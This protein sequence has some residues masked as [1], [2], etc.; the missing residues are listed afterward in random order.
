MKRFLSILIV[1]AF[2]SQLF[3]LENT[4]VVSDE[5]NDSKIQVYYF[6]LSRRC[7]TCQAVESESKKA[8]EAL[9]PEKI[10]NGE[11]TFLSVNIEEDENK[12]LAESLEV[13]GQTLLFVMGDKKVNLTNDGF[14]Y[15]K[16][17]PDKLQIKFKETIDS[18]LE[19]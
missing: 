14:M 13:S 8:L 19:E 6:H 18:F 2:A 16:T 3:A 9:Y 7:A 17:S 11:L 4:T 5:N 15:A 10:E 1:F 12:A